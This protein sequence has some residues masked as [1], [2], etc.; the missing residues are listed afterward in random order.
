MSLNNKYNYSPVTKLSVKD[1]R[2]LGNVEIDFTKSPIV[3]LKGGNEA[4]KSSVV[5]AL[6]ALGSNLGQ[7]QYKEYIRTGT[8]S[9]VVALFTEDGRVAYRKK[10]DSSQELGTYITSNNQY[11][12]AWSSDK[13]DDNSV[14]PEIQEITGFISEPETK[15]LLNVRTYEN[16]MLF[17]ETSGGTNHKVMY[18]ALKIE[19][20]TQAIKNGT[21][22]AKELKK[23]LDSYSNSVDTCRE[24]LRKIRTIDIE[25]I[26]KMKQR[27]LKEK[28]TIVL[29]EKAMEL[30]NN[31]NSINSQLGVYSELG[32]LPKLDEYLFTNLENAMEAKKSI[33]DISK[34]TETFELVRQLKTIDTNIIDKLDNALNCKNEYL[35]LQTN[36]YSDL[37]KC[38]LIDLNV[39]EKLEKGHQLLD[40]FRQ[41][42]ELLS[43]YNTETPQEISEDIVLKFESI[44]DKVNELRNVIMEYNQTKAVVDNFYATLDKMG[45]KYTICPNCSEIIL[46]GENHNE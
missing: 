1:F 10:S 40:E 9:W 32:E 4:G 34:K 30:Q 15:E 5:L 44:V 17:V 16:S 23:S 13:L 29:F 7:R 43:I 27:I 20:V 28:S 45:V 25:P 2:N 26:E 14:P 21:T 6:K 36:I 8:D 3:C 24:E 31:L 33:D 22:E 46:P 37:D 38:D 18:N 11:E 19:N 42:D 39:Y 41:G 12:L 35:T